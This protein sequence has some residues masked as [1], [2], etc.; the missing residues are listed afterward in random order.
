MNRMKKVK[1]TYFKRSGKYY[2]NGEYRTDPMMYYD[3]VTEVR[4]MLNGGNL[5]GLVDGC[6][7]FD[8]LVEVRNAPPHL[9]RC[10]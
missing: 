3:I 8:I 5:P 6:K 7:E 9:I 1:L 2:A 10:A 4:R